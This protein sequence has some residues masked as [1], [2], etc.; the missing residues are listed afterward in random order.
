MMAAMVTPVV[1]DQRDSI[2][3]VYAPSYS[4]CRLPSAGHSR[5]TAPTFIQRTI[6]LLE[7]AFNHQLYRALLISSKVFCKLSLAY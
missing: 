3:H 7:L 1:H 5:H 2:F 4:A 6:H